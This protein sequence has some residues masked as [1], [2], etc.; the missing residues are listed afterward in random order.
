MSEAMREAVANLAES[1]QGEPEALKRLGLMVPEWLAYAQAK[2][3]TGKWFRWRITE[4]E[5]QAAVVEILKLF[6]LFKRPRL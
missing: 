3:M 2:H 4:R 1:L 5:Y 6:E